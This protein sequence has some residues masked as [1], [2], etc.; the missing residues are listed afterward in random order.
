MPN[1]G[2]ARRSPNCAGKHSPTLTHSYRQRHADGV[3]AFRTAL[4]TARAELRTWMEPPT[5]QDLRVNAT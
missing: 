5:L 4:E 3:T 1:R 2:A